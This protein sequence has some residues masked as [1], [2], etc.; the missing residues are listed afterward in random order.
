MIKNIAEAYKDILNDKQLTMFIIVITLLRLIWSYVVPLGADEAY[1]FDWSKDIHLSYYDHPPGVSWLAFA[2]EIFFG[3][4]QFGARFGS[5]VAQL[6]SLVSLVAIMKVYNSKAS[7]KQV[8]TLVG[9]SALAPIISLG[10]FFI[11]PDIGLILFLSLLLLKVSLLLKKE[12][13][14]IKDALIC[15]VLWG[16]AFN[17]KYHALAIGGG[18]MFALFTLRFKKIP[19]EA[20]FWVFLTITPIL[21]AFPVFYWNYLNEWISF[22]FQTAHGFADPKFNLTTGLRTFLGQLVL[23]TPIVLYHYGKSFLRAKDFAYGYISFWTTAPLGLLLFVLSFYKEVL[24]HWIIPTVWLALPLICSTAH[25]ISQKFLKINLLYGAILIIAITS[26]FGIKP[27]KEIALA[28]MDNK[29]GPL[30]ELTIWDYIKEDPRVSQYMSRISSSNCKTQLASLRWFST[31]QIA[32]RFPENKVYNL[33][34]N[35]TSY[36]AYRDTEYPNGCPVVLIGNKKHYSEDY[37]KQFIDVQSQ[38]VFSP[39]LHGDH[40]YVILNGFWK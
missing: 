14:S 25:A 29:T 2:G 21:V 5:I 16:M 27:I 39:R 15:G 40:S 22:K 19:K 11:M 20:F 34:K 17:F 3:E 4:N 26:L 38:E 13:L 1:Y 31:A 8:R 35:Y 28:K 32:A 33:D 36:Y 12:H 7:A 10:S 30:A 23:L 9:I 18:S 24:P 6:I 37:I